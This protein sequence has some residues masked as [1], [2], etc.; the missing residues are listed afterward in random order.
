[1]RAVCMVRVSSPVTLRGVDHGQALLPLN[2][3]L[4]LG[5][6]QV[7]LE[8]VH[9]A[10]V[11]PHILDPQHTKRERERENIDVEKGSLRKMY[12]IM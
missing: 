2:A 7:P 9:A 10:D 12:A 3:Q 8:R 4:V 6:L 11:E 5:R 1:M